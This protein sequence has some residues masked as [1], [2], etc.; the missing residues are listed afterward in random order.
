[1]FNINCHPYKIWTSAGPDSMQNKVQICVDLQKN[2]FYIFWYLS[3]IYKNQEKGEILEKAYS[4][5]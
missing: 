1:M 3:D 2:V 4:H 5:I